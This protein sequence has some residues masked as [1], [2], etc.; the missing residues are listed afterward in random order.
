MC[1]ATW[2]IGSI[3]DN[4]ILALAPQTEIYWEEIEHVRASTFVWGVLTPQGATN[5]DPM[6][7]FGGCISVPW[8]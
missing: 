1:C 8:R 6:G 2:V 3:R 5:A 4:I 7:K